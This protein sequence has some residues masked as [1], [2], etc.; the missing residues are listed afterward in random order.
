MNVLRTVVALLML[1]AI[2]AIAAADL[3]LGGSPA[4]E[5]SVT[6]GKPRAALLCLHGLGLH[7]GTFD[8]FG[9]RMA[10]AG[11]VT[12]AVDLPGFGQNQ[13]TSGN[14]L[15][16]EA[17]MKVVGAALDDVRKSN[18]EIPVFLAG[19]SMGGAIALHA[20]A[21]YPDRING[22]I[23]S[24]PSGD[25]FNSGGSTAKIALK[26]LTGFNKPIP[27]GEMVVKQATEDP[28]LRAA[29]LND[30]AARLTLSP[31]ELMRFQNFMNE[32]FEYARKLT[33][34]PVLFIQGSKDKLVRPAGTWDLFDYLNTPDRQRVLSTNS[35]H[36][37]LE[38]SRFSDDDFK[39]V[40]GWMDKR[41]P[42][43]AAADKPAATPTSDSVQPGVMA[44][45]YWI[46]LLRD[47]KT[48]R[49]NNKTVF[50]T[51]DEI[52][53]HFIPQSDGYAYILMTAGSSGN[54]AVLFPN[55][56]TGLDNRLKKGRDYAL[57]TAAMLKFDEHPGIERVNLIF[58]PTPIDAKAFLASGA[59]TI[60]YLSP[61]HSGAKDLV[62]T[63]MELT[64]EDS[65]PIIMPE[66]VQQRLANSSL[67]R[68]V[69]QDPGSV[70]A[71]QI[72]LEHK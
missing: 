69:Q 41:I 56:E 20:A 16:F 42:P 8:A 64:W 7:K 63:R 70:L 17:S 36:L 13:N 46:E 55:A 6:E 25:R 32:N 18:P 53:F 26:A 12:Y 29:W 66:K 72:A 3:K 23:S 68:I 71:V 67:V 33:S 38:E 1:L 48:Y 44:L 51:G 4:L 45:N 35:E 59:G 34:V 65:A 37:I 39:Y 49:C 28:K 50:Q 61:D 24:V 52:R 47:G 2:P 15:D 62:P 57:P 31:H 40:L 60:A 30:P 21:I 19:E 54:Q 14:R 11:I 43:P 27:V 9:K 10:A 58:S 5:W 22:L